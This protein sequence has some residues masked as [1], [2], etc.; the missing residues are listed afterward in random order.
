MLEIV[1]NK[2]ALS[3]SAIS[4]IY[5]HSNQLTGAEKY[6]QYSKELQLLYAQEDFIQYLRSVFFKEHG[7]VIVFWIENGI[8]RSCLRLEPYQDGFLLTGLE[9]DLE[10]RNCGYASALVSAVLM[11]Q[12]ILC[13]KPVYSHV[14][15][16]NHASM[17]VHRKVGFQII[18][19]YAT[20]LDGTVSSSAN[21][22]RYL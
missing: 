21:T 22:L 16:N 7:A 3:E 10:F 12:E 9:T 1:R 15:K 17:R 14:A 6:P 19:D 2:D 5:R 8:Y 20:F 11:N 18:A 13:G 4:R